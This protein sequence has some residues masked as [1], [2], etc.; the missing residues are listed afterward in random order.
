MLTPPYSYR[1][2]VLEVYDGDTITA[3]LD[4]GFD[5]QIKRKIRLTGLDAP[6]IRGQE[7]VEGIAARDY[8]RDLILG[9]TVIID[10]IKDKQEKYGRYLGT[11]W[12]DSFDKS[13]NQLLIESTHATVYNPSGDKL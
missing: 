10:T 9:K 13:V 8:L 7:K 3:I 12:L 11:I 4:L 5:V 2:H 6:E 1:A